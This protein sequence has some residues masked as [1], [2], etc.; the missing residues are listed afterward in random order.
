MDRIAKP[1]VSPNIPLMMDTQ[2]IQEEDEAGNVLAT[3]VSSSDGR[4]DVIVSRLCLSDSSFEIISYL[5]DYVAS[6]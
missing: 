1:E 2:R 4:I 5:R 3:Y 6:S